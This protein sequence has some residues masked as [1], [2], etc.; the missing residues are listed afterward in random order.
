MFATV[1]NQPV[2][3]LF[4]GAVMRSQGSA[5][6]LDYDGTLAPFSVDRGQAFPYAG[7]TRVLAD[8]MRTGYTRVA[9]IT[10]RDAREVVSLL[11]IEPAPEIWGAHGLQRLGPDGGHYIPQLDQDVLQALWD[12]QTWLS[13]HSLADLAEVKPGGI[14]IH[15]RGMAKLQI[16]EIRN[17]VLLGWFPIAQRSFMSVLEFDGGLEM[18]ARE[19]DK[20]DAVQAI[21]SELQKDAPIAYLGDDNTDERAFRALGERGLSVLVRPVRRKTS[22]KLWLKPPEE[23]LDF[24]SRWNR[25]CRKRKTGSLDGR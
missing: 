3:D 5:L 25:A 20:G 6:L 14:A 10:G 2:L 17:Q 12:A 4:F 8:I 16:E 13:N 15:W 21:I 7:V 24:L 18:R 19:C 1:D 23:L 11:G 22:A 9:I